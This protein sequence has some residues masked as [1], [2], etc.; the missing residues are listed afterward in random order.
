MKVRIDKYIW[1]VRLC[2]TRSKAAEL[3]RKGKVKLNHTSV[4]PSKELEI[5]DLLTISKHNAVF[6]YRIKELIEKRVGAKLV[7]EYLEDT[8]PPEEREKLQQFLL[9]QKKY[10]HHGTGKPTKKERREIE[11]FKNNGAL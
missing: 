11:T 7:A 6:S 4:K 3:V 2:K 1:A 10:Q 9:V 8:T 5:N